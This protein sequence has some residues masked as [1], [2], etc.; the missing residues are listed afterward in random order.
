MGIHCGKP[1]VIS[2]T[3]DS[4][5][6]TSKT[7]EKLIGPPAGC[8]PTEIKDS[9]LLSA[10]R[11][12]G[13][14]MDE[15]EAMAFLFAGYDRNEKIAS[16]CPANDSETLQYLYNKKSLSELKSKAAFSELY[17]EDDH[18]H[19][20]IITETERFFDSCHA[21]T[22]VL[23]GAIFHRIDSLWY[24]KALN[25]S[26]AA[27]GSWGKAPTNMSLV[28]I[29]PDLH[30]VFVRD[31]FMAQGDYQENLFVVGPAGDRVERLFFFFDAAG[32][33]GYCREEADKDADDRGK[34]VAYDSTTTFQRGSDPDYFDIE[35]VREGT[36]YDDY[37]NVK[38]FKE[39]FSYRF[40]GCSYVKGPVG[41]FSD[42]RPFYIQ[43]AAF[44]KYQSANALAEKLSN[45][46]YPSYCEFQ[47]PDEGSS[48]FR[49]RI[50]NDGSSA[51]ADRILSEI[52]RLGHNGII[53]QP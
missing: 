23:G 6:K 31:R 53:S 9:E 15:D 14:D 27:A 41:I 44:A 38:P 34:C 35:I 3:R 30:A 20:L 46:G 22:V 4:R 50:G 29:G 45:K 2:N 40:N 51:E 17:Q 43:I 19:F 7:P 12:V 8:T 5:D 11:A 49:V 32:E 47:K 39:V 24:L 26:I 16:W 18:P 33:N 42:D 21:C 48:F 36:N 37:G 1:H 13:T 52:M 25:R 10:G 28:E